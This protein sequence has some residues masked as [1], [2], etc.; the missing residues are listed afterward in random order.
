MAESARAAARRLAVSYRGFLVGA[1]ALVAL[2]ES[3]R[4]VL[5]QGAN[6]SP[7]R[8]APKRCAEVHIMDQIDT[9]GSVGARILV[10][11]IA[12]P[13]DPELIEGVTGRATL[14]LGSCSGCLYRMSQHPACSDDMPLLSTGLTEGSPLELGTLG[15]RRADQTGIEPPLASRQLLGLDQVPDLG[16]TALVAA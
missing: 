1:A 13:S 10:C 12:G 14:T 16:R 11:C 4:V 15:S 9:L 5:L 3:D 6:N 8:G 7:Y 2:P